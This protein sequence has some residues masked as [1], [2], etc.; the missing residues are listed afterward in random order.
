MHLSRKLTAIIFLC[1]GFSAVD[2]LAA[3]I[4]L[5]GC[6][7]GCRGSRKAALEKD[8]T[9]PFDHSLSSTSDAALPNEDG[10]SPPPFILSLSFEKKRK[11]K[12]GSSFYGTP[13]P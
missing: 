5:L 1:I 10:R 4:G 6:L 9:P 2:V 3:P 8:S 11:N 7:K 13:P 12:K